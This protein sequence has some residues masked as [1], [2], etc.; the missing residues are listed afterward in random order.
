[1]KTQQSFDI[2]SRTFQFGVR[3]VKLIDHLPRTTA[4]GEIGRQLLR[5][6]TSVGANVR[7]AGSA[8]S[9]KDFVHKIAIARKETQESHFWLEL[10][11]AAILPSDAE[12]T[13]LTDESDQLARILQA[14]G[15]RKQQA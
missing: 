11:N 1:L 6:G 3:V 14:I 13:A 8:E 7:E 12:V 4:G 9:H 5:S 10:I 15:H 2:Y